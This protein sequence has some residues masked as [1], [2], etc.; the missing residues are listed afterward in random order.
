[1]ESSSIPLIDSDGSI[2]DHTYTGNKKEEEEE[3]ARETMRGP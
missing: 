2:V 3:E 1:M